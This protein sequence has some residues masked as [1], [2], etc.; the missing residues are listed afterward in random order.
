M[1][2]PAAPL[3][4]KKTLLVLALLEPSHSVCEA[5]STTPWPRPFGR[6][7]ANTVAAEYCCAGGVH[8]RHCEPVAAAAAPR[9]VAFAAVHVFVQVTRGARAGATEPK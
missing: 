9:H 1:P 7:V 2:L 4:Q 6:P 3:G 8:C 5:P